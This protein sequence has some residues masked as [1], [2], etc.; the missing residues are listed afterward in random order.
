MWTKA[1][2]RQRHEI[3]Q[4]L[5][6]EFY[7]R[8]WEVVRSNRRLRIVAG[9][10]RAGKSFVSAAD[11]FSRLPWGM[12][13]WLVGPDYYQPRAEFE[14]LETWLWQLDAIRGKQAIK[15]PREGSWEVRLKS[16]QLIVTRTSADVR[17][18]AAR[19]VDGIL[20]CE[21]G[22]QSYATYLKCLGRTSQSRGFV[23]ASGTFETSFDWYADTFS[24]WREE[25]EP[26]G[27]AFSLPTWG[28]IYIFPGGREDPEILRL[29]RLYE[30][31]P[32]YFM[33]KCGAQPSPPLGVIFREFSFVHHVQEGI[34]YHPDVPVY[35][36]VDPG[37]GG[38]SAYAVVVCQFFPDP[39]WDELEYP[40]EDPI[41][42][43]NVVD[44]LYLPGAD[45]DMVKSV[46][47]KAPWYENVRGGAIDC[48]APDERKRWLRHL[49]IHLTSKKVRI[50]EGERRLHTF[51]H[52]G[53][54]GPHLRISGEVGDTALR[55]FRK[56][57]TPVNSP[58]DIEARPSRAAGNRRG[59]E[60]FLKA[61][62][63]LLYSRYGPVKAGQ[64]PSPYVREAW[65]RVKD[66]FGV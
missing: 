28:N 63:Y 10:E 7:P 45:F 43:C 3:L 53:A 30:P 15:K 27:T 58:V 42:Y 44:A 59:P 18:L 38:P 22:Q 41:D 34:S 2:W 17:K 48:E 61:L 47:E 9:G 40:A 6:L 23:L 39:H 1:T 36:G 24:T 13:F 54:A 37:H 29:E 55:E 25:E 50:I 57:T 52:K 60:H 8:Q 35:L 21:A 32:G 20:M 4:A 19:S 5:G 64:L 66:A 51:L 62:W 65:R 26:E 46:V 33:E 49:G 12:E 14:Y 31:M 56:Y 16:G 11:M